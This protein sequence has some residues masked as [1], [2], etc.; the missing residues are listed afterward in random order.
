MKADP[1]FVLPYLSLS[2]L[3]MQAKRW[4]KLADV[5]ETTVKLDPFDYPQAYFFNSVANFNLRNLEAA[6]KSALQ[7]ERLDT[8][9]QFPKV[10]HLLGLIMADRKDWGGAAQRF[11]EYLKWAPKATDA[12]AVRAQLAQVEKIQAQVA[13][14]K[15]Q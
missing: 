9:H 13:S 15:D 4:Q 1:K 14:A 11:K 8:R 3:E 10:N 2:L 6:E 5:T 7:A 12:D